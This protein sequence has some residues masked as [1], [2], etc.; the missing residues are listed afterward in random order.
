MEPCPAARPRV[1]RWGSY[2]PPRYR[3]WKAE[4]A[5][6]IRRICSFR[7]PMQGPLSVVVHVLCT[8]PRTSVLAHPRP[9][10]DNYAKAVLDGM[11]GVVYHDDSQIISLLVTKEW[12]D[13]GEPGRIT[14]KLA[15]AA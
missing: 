9:D 8:R 11:N 5:Q 13:Q 10:V 1:S 6:E 7:R 12:T 4:F 14:I 15:P 2:Y 3:R